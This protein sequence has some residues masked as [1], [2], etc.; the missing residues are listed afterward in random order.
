MKNWWIW[1]LAAVIALI[2]I[3]IG[4]FWGGVVVFAAIGIGA[5]WNM[6]TRGPP[7]LV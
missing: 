2:A 6:K 7:S 1:L 4:G 3:M 5:T